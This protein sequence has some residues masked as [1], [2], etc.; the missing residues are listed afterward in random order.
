MFHSQAR[1]AGR[2][3]TG[4]SQSGPDFQCEVP[5]L[6]ALGFHQGSTSQSAR[7]P[8]SPKIKQ[9]SLHLTKRKEGV[10]GGEQ[11]TETSPCHQ[12]PKEEEVGDE[13]CAPPA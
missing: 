11:C 4:S 10:E 3:I 7:H 12:H 13:C 2:T 9:L 1:G 8:A 6:A 5:S